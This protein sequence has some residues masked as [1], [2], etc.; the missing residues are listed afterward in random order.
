VLVAGEIGD[1][2]LQAGIL[3]AQLPWLFDLDVEARFAAAEW[4][5]HIGRCPPR[6]LLA[7]ALVMC[8]SVTRVLFIVLSHRT[9]AFDGERSPISKCLSIL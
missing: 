9:A 8:S 6:L 3:V 7:Q 4:P 5:A 1:Q 2:A